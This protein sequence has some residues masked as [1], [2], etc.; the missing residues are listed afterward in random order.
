MRLDSDAAGSSCTS[1]GSIYRDQGSLRWMT[2]SAPPTCEVLCLNAALPDELCRTFLRTDGVRIEQIV[3]HGHA[4]P[5]RYP[6][7][8]LRTDAASAEESIRGFAVTP[9]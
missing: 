6:V 9:F 2:P 4:S 7:A 1:T 3:S 8:S 5:K